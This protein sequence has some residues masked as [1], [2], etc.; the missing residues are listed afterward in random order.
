[1]VNKEATNVGEQAQNKDLS[2]EEQQNLQAAGTKLQGLGKRFMKI[3]KAIPGMGSQEF[4]DIHKENKEKRAD[5]KATKKEEKITAKEDK[6]INASKETVDKLNERINKL[7]E[8]NDTLETNIKFWK[9]ELDKA[10]KENGADKSGN[11]IQN[12]YSSTKF[13]I[14]QKRLESLKKK[15]DKRSSKEESEYTTL[16][17]KYGEKNENRDSKK[18]G[19]EAKIA[20]AENEKS[21]NESELERLKKDF[22][23]AHDTYTNQKNA[24]S[25]RKAAQSVKTES[26]DDDASNDVASML[27]ELIDT[28]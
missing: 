22:N 7:Q 8:R 18:S 26:A 15:G 4:K 14:E 13:S 3:V 11:K 27:S 17:Q 28:L 24:Q 6:K 1:M 9:K 21:K 19:L 5:E 20:E 23:N 2:P 25:S 10:S 12:A 16:L